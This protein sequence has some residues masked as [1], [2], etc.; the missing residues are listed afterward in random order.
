MSLDEEVK[1][2]TLIE[3]APDAIFLVDMNTGRIREVNDRAV[4]LLGYDR[5]ELLG[6]P[7]ETIHPSEDTDRYVAKFAEAVQRESIQFSKLDD[8]TQVSLVA[9]DGRSIP[10]DINV[11]VVQSK[12]GPVLFGVARDVSTL[13][14]YE[15]ELTQLAGELA[16]VNRIVR[17]DICNDMAVILGWLEQLKSKLDGSHQDTLGMLLRRTEAVV[18]LTETVKDY[19][20]M[21][22]SDA[23]V[24]LESVLLGPIIEEEATATR[25]SYER[26]VISVGDI[27]NRPVLANSMLASV[28]RNLFHNAVQHNDTDQPEIEVTAEETE[29]TVVVEV[30]DNGRGI[31]DERKEN[32]FGKGNKG[33]DS[34][35]T[36]IGLYLIGEL[37]D[38]FGG[39]VSVW[40]NDPE[41]TVFSV[42]LQKP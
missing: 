4:E 6:E 16:V 15:D 24:R 8:G 11:T 31:P 25:Q 14:Q 12:Q 17:H 19:V 30:A 39:S 2:R 18:Q 32:I 26:A 9:K 42:E 41:G 33:L 28:F 1:Y 22:E 3:T 13:K 37:V 7:V 20:E 10:V 23:D 36:G 29:E 21:L 35:G 5:S 38:R 34:S 27:P 40:D